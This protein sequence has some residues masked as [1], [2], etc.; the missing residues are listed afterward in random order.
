MFRV[1]QCPPR[2]AGVSAIEGWW[3]LER[4]VGVSDVSSSVSSDDSYPWGSG[5]TRY[6]RMRTR[7]PAKCNR[8]ETP[9]MEPKRL[10]LVVSFLK[11]VKMHMQRSARS[12]ETRLVL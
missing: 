7:E 9:K 3:E 10:R 4:K 6:G 12:Q 11:S 5:P 2:A 8:K 1:Y